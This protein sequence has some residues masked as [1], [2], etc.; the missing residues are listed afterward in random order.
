MQTKTFDYDDLG[1]RL[2]LSPR[3]GADVVDAPN[4]A[5]EYGGLK[6]GD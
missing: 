1:N 3:T 4:I 5:N 6:V 2:T